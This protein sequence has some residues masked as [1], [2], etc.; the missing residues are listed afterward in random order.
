M[1]HPD[2]D[3]IRMVKNLPSI[4]AVQTLESGVLRLRITRFGRK[5][6]RELGEALEARKGWRILEL[7]LRAHAGGDMRRM[8]RFTALFTGPVPR[9]VRLYGARRERWLAIPEAHPPALRDSLARITL[10]LII[11]PQTASSAEV[12]AALLKK[13]ARA[14]I[15]GTRSRGK[16]WLHVAIPVRQGWQLLVP[17]ARME[18][19]GITL[20]GGLVPD[21]ANHVRT[22]PRRR[23]ITRHCAGWRDAN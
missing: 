13:H 8:L 2:T 9:A 22:F 10:R 12:F 21:V 18:V 20:R 4:T 5:A 19:P 7:D 23:Q 14:R 3:S 6:A 17:H 15:I 11:G 1:K 16:D